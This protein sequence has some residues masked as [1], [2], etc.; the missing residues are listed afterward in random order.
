MLDDEMRV[1]CKFKPFLCTKTERMTYS[2][3]ER[4][5]KVGQVNNVT[6]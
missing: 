3:N 5:K 1:I 2:Q 6:I 4:L